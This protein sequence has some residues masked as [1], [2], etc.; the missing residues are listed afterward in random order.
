MPIYTNNFHSCTHGIELQNIRTNLYRISGIVVCWLKMNFEEEKQMSDNET[1][2]LD[3][4]V[5]FE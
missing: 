2:E 3:D 5:L 4:T 1:E